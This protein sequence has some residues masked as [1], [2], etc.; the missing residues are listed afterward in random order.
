MNNDIYY[1]DVF[2]SFCHAEV[3]FVGAPYDLDLIDGIFCELCI[4]QKNLYWQLANT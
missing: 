4:S 2:Q 3:N 1:L